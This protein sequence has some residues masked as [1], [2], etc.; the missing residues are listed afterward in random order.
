FLS[1]GTQD[2]YPT[3]LRVQRHFS[4]RLSGTVVAVYNVGA[5][6]GGLALGLFSQAFGRR[7]ALVFAALLSLPVVGLWAFSTSALVLAASAFLMQFMVQGC[8]GVVP[9]HLN[10]LSP[11]AARGTF[12][13]FVYQ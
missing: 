2:L 7:R 1:H 5:I 10:E 12:P 13:G 3:F 8:W 9:A 6:L 11:A 4:P